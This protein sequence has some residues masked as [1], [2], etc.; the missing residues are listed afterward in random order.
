L[1]K[2]AAVRK[3]LRTKFLQQHGPAWHAIVSMDVAPL[4]LSTMVAGQWFAQRQIYQLTAA[5]HTVFHIF[6]L[7]TLP[8]VL[9]R[10]SATAVHTLLVGGHVYSLLMLYIAS[11]NI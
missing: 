11:G 6:R 1:V 2:D 3:A 8:N 7:R 4:I 9:R 5:Y 10:S